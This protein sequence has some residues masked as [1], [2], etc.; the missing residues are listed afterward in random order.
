RRLAGPAQQQCLVVDV[1]GVNRLARLRHP[2]FYVDGP[3]ALRVLHSFPTRRSSDL[4]ADPTDRRRRLRAESRHDET[5]LVRV[6]ELNE[7]RSE[8]HTS[9]LQSRSDLVCRLLLEKKK[10]GAELVEGG[11]LAPVCPDDAYT[12]SD[13]HT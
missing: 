10:L 4:A 2:R 8:E 9:E 13:E 5:P 11:E 7:A 12:R 3:G 6:I 1:G